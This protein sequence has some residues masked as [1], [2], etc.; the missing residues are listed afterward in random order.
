MQ[1]LKESVDCIRDVFES[2][3]PSQLHPSSSLALVQAEAM[4]LMSAAL[5]ML[6]AEMPLEAGMAVAT[7]TKEAATMRNCILIV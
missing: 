5:W 7:A 3:L 2:Y 6:V 4:L 1:A